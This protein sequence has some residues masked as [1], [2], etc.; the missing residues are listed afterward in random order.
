MSA[1]DIK[2][3]V[4]ILLLL[5]TTH[6]GDGMAFT[7]ILTNMHN[8]VLYIGSTKNLAKRHY[9]H[10]QSLIEGFSKRYK[11]TKL[12]YFETFDSMEDARKRETQLK[13]TLRKRKIALIN[14]NNPD[15]RELPCESETS[16]ER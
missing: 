8:N 3:P 10:K 5:A 11:T 15:W 13:K 9:M 4:I 6:V 2:I 7:Y 1:H 12:V 14:A 16:K